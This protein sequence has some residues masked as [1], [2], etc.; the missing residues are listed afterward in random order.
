MDS[1][2]LKKLSRQDL[3]RM[4]LQQT[5]ISEDLKKQND[6][7]K[8]QLSIKQQ[9]VESSDSLVEAQ[10]KLDGVF[11]SAKDVSEKI[12]DGAKQQQAQT[13]LYCKMMIEETQKGCKKMIDDARQEA[14]SYLTEAKKQVQTMIDENLGTNR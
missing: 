12:V 9:T 1:K 8:K 5:K 4:L 3:L 2:K 6:D 7:L 10:L 11:E 14:D 13:E